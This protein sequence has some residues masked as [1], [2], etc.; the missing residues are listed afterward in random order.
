MYSW[1]PEE[2]LQLNGVKYTVNSNP[3]VRIKCPAC[4]GNKCYYNIRTGQWHDFDASCEASG[5][6]RRF[7]AI[8]NNL[9]LKEA[10]ADIE[11]QL[12][13]TPNSKNEVRP[14]REVMKPETIKQ[15]EVASAEVLNDTYRAFLSELSL[16]E[17]HINNLKARGFTENRIEALGYKS[18]PGK[19]EV[20]FFAICKRLQVDGHKLE[21]VPGFFQYKDGRWTFV[22]RTKGI[23]MPRVNH[24]NQITGL[25]IRKDDDLRTFIQNPDGSEELEPKC[26]WFSSKGLNNGC[27]AF[28]AIHYSCDF[29]FEKD[30]LKDKPVIEQK[31]VMLTEGI[32][33]GD[34]VNQIQ[35][36]IPVIAVQGVNCLKDFKEELLFL[37]KE[38]NLETVIMGYDMDYKSNP[39]VQAAL[40]K[41]KEIIS[42]CGLQIRDL[43]WETEMT[44]NGNTFYLKGIDDYLAY[45]KLGITPVIK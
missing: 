30:E 15:A 43:D 3:N 42:E 22:Y 31:G 23:I 32:M 45:Y 17:K 33:K 34:L 26:A 21:G 36:N 24:Y 12:H 25:Q 39:N 14:A 10:G 35:P 18:M 40:S 4:G 16:S 13:I 28:T 29:K 19:D 41:A 20:D 44:V 8:M 7:H 2:V 37:K 9:S 27:G 6:S 11:R 38:A 1:T 5:D